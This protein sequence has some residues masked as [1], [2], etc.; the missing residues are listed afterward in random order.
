MADWLY[1]PSKYHRL[2][3]I[4]VI[5]D[6]DPTI[7][8]NQQKILNGLALAAR[9]REPDTD[10]LNCFAARALGCVGS[11]ARQ[12]VPALRAMLGAATTSNARAE[13]A[14]ALWRIEG[15]TNLLPVLK[16]EL[17]RIL[18]G[19][20][21]KR[22]ETALRE[23]EAAIKPVA[24][25]DQP[26]APNGSATD[27][28]PASGTLAMQGPASMALDIYKAIAGVDFVMEFQGPVPGLI[29]VRATRPL[30]QNEAMEFLENALL[31]QC[32]IVLEHVD[33][34]HIAVKMRHQK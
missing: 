25:V 11:N 28:S 15:D 23:M 2:T 22:V 34:K 33:E 13:A 4:L 3:A 31:D 20:P 30:S 1:D 16:R 19:P 6:I 9:Q 17:G 12:A 8:A 18:Q 21:A 32:G 7:W 14:I 29:N 5:S 27:A 24:S 10:E 26:R